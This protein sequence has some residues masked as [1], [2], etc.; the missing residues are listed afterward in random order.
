MLPSIIFAALFAASSVDALY[1]PRARHVHARHAVNVR[2]AQPVPA[3]APV[4]EPLAEASAARRRK[5]RRDGKCKQRPTSTAHAAA[6]SSAAAVPVNVAP[7][8]QA[9]KPT[10]SKKADPKPTPAPAPAPA[11]APKPS[12]KPS[13]APAPSNP[14]GGGARPFGD[15]YAGLNKGGDGTFYQPGL[16]ACGEVN[17]E[18]ELVA[19]VPFGLWGAVPGFNSPNPNNNPICGHMIDVFYNNKSVRVKVV[20]ECMG[21]YI[22]TSLDMSPAAF[23]MIADPAIGRIHD[24]QWRWAS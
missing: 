2:A 24:I 13:P 21:C 12:P 18:N 4:A 19:A 3:P 9:P 15:F 6:T 14:G 23:N 10:S 16:G 11:P 22:N 1:T 5:A 17:N 8:P 20:D 7:V